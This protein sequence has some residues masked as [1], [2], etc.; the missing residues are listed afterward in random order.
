MMVR[1]FGGGPRKAT[2]TKAARPGPRGPGPKAIGLV[3]FAAATGTLP[4]HHELLAAL[5]ERKGF[6]LVRVVEENGTPDTTPLADRPALAEAIEAIRKG[7]ARILIVADLGR[8][9]T[10][11]GQT[12]EI[13]SLLEEAGG[14][15]CDGETGHML[16]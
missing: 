2:G 6:E 8:I 13:V 10:E 3:R 14:S 4:V 12:T 7:E 16:C 9:V 15:L 5:C 11:L 1:G